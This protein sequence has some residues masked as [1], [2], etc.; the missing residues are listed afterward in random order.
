[1]RA[2]VPTKMLSPT[3]RRRLELATAVAQERILATHVEHALGLIE[4]VGDQV[5]FDAAMDIYNRLLRMSAEEARSVTTRALAHIGEHAV[6]AEIWP[7]LMAQSARAEE[8]RGGKG[9]EPKQAAPADAPPAARSRA[10][11]AGLRQRMRGRVND[12]LR[13]RIELAAARTEVALLRTHTDNALAFV[14]V[15]EEELSLPEA[16]ETYIEALDLRD[17]VAEMVYYHALA[18]I[19]D[20]RLPPR[21]TTARLLTGRPALPAVASPDAP[22]PRLLRTAEG[23]GA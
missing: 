19:A 2:T 7:E 4:M 10:L 12:D 17:T 21:R 16:V 22:A 14:E 13:Q 5:P 18:H 23:K 8:Q 6:A 3:V 1:M 15:L 9:S 11:F 20:Q